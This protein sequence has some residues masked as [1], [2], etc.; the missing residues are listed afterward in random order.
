MI[1]VKYNIESDKLRAR[2][3]LLIEHIEY[4]IKLVGVDYVGI[5]SDFDGF[6]VPPQKLD[7]ISTYP[8]IT[9]ALVEKGYAQ[10]GLSKF[11]GGNVLKVLKANEVKLNIEGH[12]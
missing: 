12:R 2:F 7:D 6:V 5:G 10:K 11:L 8:L 9:K 3:A 4:F 1:H